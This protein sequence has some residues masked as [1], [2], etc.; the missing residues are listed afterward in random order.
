MYSELKE[1]QGF[2]RGQFC[3]KN[4]KEGEEVLTHSAEQRKLVKKIE[5]Q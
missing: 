3:P 1:E 5:V 2:I 4:E